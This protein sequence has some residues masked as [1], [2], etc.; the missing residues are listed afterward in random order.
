VFRPL[1]DHQ[2]FLG[3]FMRHQSLHI[4]TTSCFRIAVAALLALIAIPGRVMAEQNIA[5]AASTVPQIIQF[6]GSL[7]G[8]SANV[9]TATVSIAF[10][11][12]ENEQG[13]TALWSETQNVTVNGQGQYTVMLGAASTDGLPL[14]LFSTVQARWLQA[15]P[16]GSEYAE[17]PRV[18]LVGVPYAM[19]AADAETIGGLPPSAFMRAIPVTGASSS[20]ESSIAPT[21]PLSGL[22]PAG[23]ADASPK[24]APP[25]SNVTGS[26]TTGYIAQWTTS[27]NIGNSAL[28]QLSSGSAAK[29]GI[30]TTAP[31]WPLDV[32]GSVNSSSNYKI[33]G[34]TMLAVPGASSNIA[35]GNNA[36]VADTTGTGN[37]ANG[38]SALS[39]NTTGADNTASGYNALSSN[40][41]GNYNAASGGYALYKNTTGGANSAFGYG[42]LFNNTTA[43]NNAANG[44]DALLSN[45]TGS[46]NTAGGVEALQNNTTGSSNTALGYQA[47]LTATSGN[48]NTTGS[49]NTFIGYNSGPGTSAQL[50]N[51]TAIGAN[52][53]VSQSN[54]LVL[55]GTG[56]NAVNV[57]IGTAA[58]AAALE[59]NGAAQFDSSVTFAQGGN[60]T[61]NGTVTGGVV[62]ATATYDL[63]GAAFAFGSNNPSVANVFLGFAG[64]NTTTGCCNTV[65]GYQTLLSNTTGNGNTASGYQALEYNTTGQSNTAMGLQALYLNTIGFSNTAIGYSALNNNTSDYNTAIGY[66]ALLSNT[67]AIYNTAIGASAMQNS[68]TGDQNTAIGAGAM[69]MNNT[70]VTNTA[71]GNSALVENTTGGNNVGIGSMAL[72]DNVTGSGNIAIGAGAGMYVSGDNNIEIGNE[73]GGSGSTSGAIRI[74]SSEFQTATYIAGIAGVMLPTT[75][76]PLVC[77]DPTT[78]QLGTLNCAAKGASPEEQGVIKQL[79]EQIEALQ[80]Q[81]EDFQKRLAHLETLISK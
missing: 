27:S 43:S 66:D 73:G 79:R 35:V 57:G 56:A 63:N 68:T 67:T 31:V 28:F 47:G 38:S 80:K 36:L 45:T 6:S 12:Y 11:L 33:G 10:T 15:Q 48:A 51:A 44:N 16:V 30:I 23:P 65:S 81:N 58:P 62:N 17:Q 71:V 50:T 64:N 3:G 9:P 14:N 8:A 46:D 75:N 22:P 55:G 78:G 70:G 76:E 13:G 7:S 42:A 60:L 61:T 52:A 24:K 32:T 20:P 29:V 59:V 21:S 54:S 4:F 37:S 26:G 1:H 34:S 72:A 69:Q 5:A 49:R 18:M 39:K 25:A 77:I 40:T 19:K 53:N 41:T 74:G 2:V